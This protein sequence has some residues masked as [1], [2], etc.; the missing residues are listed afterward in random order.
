[1]EKAKA[2]FLKKRSKKLLF[3]WLRPVRK[4]SAQDSK[5]FALIAEPVGRSDGLLPNRLCNKSEVFWFPP[6]G[7]RLFFKKE[8]LPYLV[9]RGGTVL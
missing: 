5:A 1:V 3:I 6:G 2:V 7:R 9:G 8:L 4:G